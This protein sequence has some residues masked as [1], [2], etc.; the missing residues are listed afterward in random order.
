MSIDR[1]FKP[2]IVQSDVISDEI[3]LTPKQIFE[4]SEY[5]SSKNSLI[6]W[7]LLT[8]TKTLLTTSLVILP[9]VDLLWLAWYDSGDDQ[10]VESVHYVADAVRIITYST[11]LLLQHKC[12]VRERDL[13]T[14][15][16]DD[17]IVEAWPGHVRTSVHILVPQR[18][19]RG[20]PLQI[21]HLRLS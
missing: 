17:L 11:V 19:L 18:C 10:K 12:Q 13:Q 15:D 20:S 3:C 7:S 14:N 6:P 8:I 21:R 1:S 5:R 2:Q 9:L 4:V 16:D